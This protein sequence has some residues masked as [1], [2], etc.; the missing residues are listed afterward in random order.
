MAAITGASSTL[1]Q[2]DI[3]LDKHS[4]K[5]LIKTIYEEAEHLNEIIRNVLD[6]TRLESGAIVVKKEWQ[7][8]EEIIGVVLNRFSEKLKDHPLS[9]N[10]SVDLPLIPFDALLIEQVLMNLLDNAIKYTP[11][12][13]PLDLSAMLK[14]GSLL[15]ELADRGPGI[16]HGEEKRIFEKF[17]RGSTA[18]GGIGLGLTICQTIITAHGGNIWAENR[19][20]GGTV[21]RFT[22][23]ITGKPKLLEMEEI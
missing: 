6:M 5:E 10:L 13:T 12:E 23:P 2:P 14:G 16:P 22:L 7:S 21:F 4:K 15:V 11:K 18:R 3:T 9:I 8:I 20:G 1:L 17:V 19:P